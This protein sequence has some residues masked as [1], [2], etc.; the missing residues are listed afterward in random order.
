MNAAHLHLMLNHFPII[1]LIISLLLFIISRIYRNNGIRQAALITFVF[2]GIMALAAYFS[3]TQAEDMMEELLPASGHLIEAHEDGGLY[4]MIICVFLGALA[5]ISLYLEKKEFKYLRYLHIGII[6]ISLLGLYVGRAVATGGGEIR[7]TEIRSG[8]D[9][10]NDA[11][12]LFKEDDDHED[13]INLLHYMTLLY[14]LSSQSLP[15]E[16]LIKLSI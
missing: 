15:V 3:G 16:R 10:V 12:G 2:T 1:G 13:G 5:A 9:A 14:G 8:S 4:F 6:V 11:S 7:H